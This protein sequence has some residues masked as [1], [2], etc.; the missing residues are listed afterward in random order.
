M[1]TLG[2]SKQLAWPLNWALSQKMKNKYTFFILPPI[3]GG[4]TK[5]TGTLYE[6]LNSVPYLLCNDRVP[7]LAVVNK[8][9]EKG[10]HDAGM[11]GGVEWAPFTIDENEYNE[12]LEQF[13]NHGATYADAPSWVTNA[14]YFQIWQFELDHGVPSKRHKKLVDEEDKAK[15]K[16]ESAIDEGLSKEEITIL[17]L[18]VIEAG[19]AVADFI[20]EYL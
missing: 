2:P 4:K 19:Q 14:T 11:S 17:H 13:E 18:K 9:L 16:L 7:P 5:E 6:L 3:G 1:H 12:L 8:I 20:D 10:G 15:E